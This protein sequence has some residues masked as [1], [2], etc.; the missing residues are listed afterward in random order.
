MIETKM[1]KRSIS[2]SFSRKVSDKFK[3]FDVFGK[4]VGV[5]AL[6]AGAEKIPNFGFLGGQPVHYDAN[7]KLSLIVSDFQQS[8][9][10]WNTVPQKSAPFSSKKE[11]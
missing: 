5:A 9:N 6:K 11:K 2:K 1:K 8:V 10:I 7:F 3:A 4:D